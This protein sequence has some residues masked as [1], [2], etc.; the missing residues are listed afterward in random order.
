MNKQN[1]GLGVVYSEG[2]LKAQ[3]VPFTTDLR[4]LSVKDMVSEVDVYIETCVVGR[5][6][7]GIFEPGAWVDVSVIKTKMA[8]DSLHCLTNIA[9]YCRGGTI[10]DT[11][12]LKVMRIAHGYLLSELPTAYCVY[13][14]IT[15]STHDCEQPIMDGRLFISNGV[16]ETN[17]G[18]INI[19][20]GAVSDKQ[21]EHPNGWYQAHALP[22]KIYASFIVEHVAT[23]PILFQRDNQWMYPLPDEGC[24]VGTLSPIM[25]ESKYTTLVTEL[26]D[27][28]G[29]RVPKS[30]YCTL[31][32]AK[33]YGMA[34]VLIS[35]SSTGD[36]ERAG[37]MASVNDLIPLTDSI[38]LEV[39][40]A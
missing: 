6:L 24:G 17:W 35:L 28:I 1:L 38:C 19:H 20:T 33:E 11:N 9:R 13:C 40:C 31:D 34:S 18:V 14:N 29:W 30:E 5:S 4:K 8:I 25:F 36:V 7:L 3:T 27:T 15:D 12:L 26:L 39:E 10:T 2:K 37:C 32:T 21:P 23:S 16:F 22:G